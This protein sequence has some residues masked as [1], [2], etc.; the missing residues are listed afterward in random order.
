[1]PVPCPQSVQGG[2]LN[3]PGLGLP[4]S[5]PDEGDLPSIVEGGRGDLRRLGVPRRA[6]L[7]QGFHVL[8]GD[9]HDPRQ[10]LALLLPLPKDLDGLR[11]ACLFLRVELVFIHPTKV[12]EPHPA[13]L[14]AARVPRHVVLPRLEPRH[15]GIELGPELRHSLRL[16]RRG[17]VVPACLDP[18][19]LRRA[20][21]S[22]KK[23]SN[24]FFGGRFNHPPRI[25][26]GACGLK[27]ME[28]FFQEKLSGGGQA[29]MVDSLY[30]S[31]H[32]KK[33]RQ[34]KQKGGGE[35]RILSQA[36]QGGIIRRPRMAPPPPPSP[37]P[38]PWRRRSQTSR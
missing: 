36:L 34:T 23:E 9:L 25:H 31:F 14:L 37:P 17:H 19:L 28:K 29:V 16:C 4:G 6:L 8:W 10:V 15:A 18:T 21:P 22:E 12:E 32:S 11:D 2:L 7:D 13:L 30:H 24:A 5:E 1:M 35:A 33:Q 27:K 26:D 38:S 3:L 20:R